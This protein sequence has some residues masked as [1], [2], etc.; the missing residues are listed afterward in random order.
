MP[1][2]IGQV[3][4]ACIGQIGTGE[5]VKI[6]RTTVFTYISAILYLATRYDSLDECVP[7]LVTQVYAIHS[8]TH[9]RQLVLYLVK[10][11]MSSTQVL[12]LVTQ[13]WSSIQVH[14]MQSAHVFHCLHL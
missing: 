6:H 8:G 11:S 9:Q 14:D 4:L 5:F 3:S 7:D 12:Y 13:V 1:T 10:R 2:R